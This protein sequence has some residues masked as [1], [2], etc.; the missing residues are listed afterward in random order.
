M[1]IKVFLKSKN[2]SDE[3]ITQLLTNDAFSPMLEGLINEAESGKTALANAQQ[4]ETNLKA[5]QQNEIIPYVRKADERAAAAEGRVSQLQ[6]HMKSMKDA[7]YDIPDAYLATS[8][9][10]VKKVEPLPS[11]GISREDFD[12][13]GMEIAETNMA[14]VSLSNRHRKLTGDELDL[15]TEYTDFKANRRPDENL[16]SYVARKYDHAGLQT[17][18][19]TE[20]HQKELDDYAAGKVAAA[21]KDWAEKN[22]SNGETRNPRASRWDAVKTDENRNKLWQTAQGRAQATKD[23]LAKYQAMVQ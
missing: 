14:L 12:K 20:K 11:N 16:R 17:K 3:Q 2:F 6:T 15:D 23:R 7:G 22:G 21:Q 8:A 18:R 9:E 10:P 19:D 1:D 5:W 13:R 4:I